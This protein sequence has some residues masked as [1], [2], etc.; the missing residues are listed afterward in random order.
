MTDLTFIFKIEFFWCT[1][2]SQLKPASAHLK[3]VF[4]TNLDQEIDLDE[5]SFVSEEVTYVIMH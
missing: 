1:H 2:L 4:S 3:I 5:T